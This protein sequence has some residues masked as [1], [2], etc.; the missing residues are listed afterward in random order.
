MR[1]SIHQ[2]FNPMY[3]AVVIALVLVLPLISIISQLLF[4]HGAVTA[5]VALPIIAKWYVFWAVG[6]RLSLAG[7]RQIIQPRYTAESILGIQSAAS[8]LLVR[9]LG[10]ANAAMGI[11][12]LRSLIAPSWVAPLALMG[13]VFY[14]LAGINHCLRPNRN[15]LQNLALASDLF[16]ALVLAICFFA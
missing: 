11:A 7:L 5:P 13:A 2:V 14:G 15:T 16:A 6:V 12:G 8:L 3:V 9:E 4:Q 10:F 1:F